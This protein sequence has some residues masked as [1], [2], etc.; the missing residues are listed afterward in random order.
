MT[1]TD[2][3]VKEIVLETN[4]KLDKFIDK[5]DVRMGKQELKDTKQ[6]E[7][8][9]GL[10]IHRARIMGNFRLAAYIISGSGILAAVVAVL[11]ALIAG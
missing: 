4:A 2:F 3:T 6:D 11:R 8:I 7:R 9:V 1:N 5:V 10:E